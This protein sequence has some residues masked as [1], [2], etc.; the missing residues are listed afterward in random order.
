MDAKE[1]LGQL[2]FLEAFIKNKIDDMQRWMD[3]ATNKTASPGQ[4]VWLRNSKGEMELHGLGRVQTSGNPHKMEDAI[5]EYVALET[6]ELYIEEIKT[7]KAT[8][9]S[10]IQL[11]EKVKK[12]QQYDLL[13]KVYV[14]GFTLQEVADAYNL[15]Y[16][17]ATT[18][19]GRALNSFAKV[20]DKYEPGWR[21]EDL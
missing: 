16:S 4:S 18:E 9:N 14:Q 15:S 19:H 5:I 10:I 21:T 8:Y 2:K 11:M 1:Y 12:W 20:L 17:W 6:D 13:H 7:A 3:I